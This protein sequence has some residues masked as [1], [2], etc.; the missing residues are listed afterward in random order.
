[1]YCFSSHPDYDCGEI[2]FWF[3]RSNYESNITYSH[4]TDEHV[5]MFKAFK[6]IWSLLKMCPDF[7][8]SEL[9][10]MKTKL[11]LCFFPIIYSLGVISNLFSLSLANKNSYKYTFGFG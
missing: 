5:K 1:M 2:R 9:N 8:I 4:Q 10:G 6:Y 3:H 11:V 7:E